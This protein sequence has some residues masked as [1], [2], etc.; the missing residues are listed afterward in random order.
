MWRLRFTGEVQDFGG[1]ESSP[2][3]TLNAKPANPELE[4]LEPEGKPGLWARIARSPEAR[5]ARRRCAIDGVLV[6]VNSKL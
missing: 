4:S 6:W 3:E 2:A 1:E 5:S